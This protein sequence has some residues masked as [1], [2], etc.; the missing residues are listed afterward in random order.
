MKTTLLYKLKNKVRNLFGIKTTPNIEVRMD[1]LN[2]KVSD[3]KRNGL[4]EMIRSHRNFSA[5]DIEKSILKDRD[6]I[7][8]KEEFNALPFSRLSE[9]AMLE[10]IKIVK[11]DLKQKSQTVENYTDSVKSTLDELSDK[12]DE[13]IK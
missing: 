8:V 2:H 10:I 6:N 4:R 3:E 7:S 1:L 12:L 9:D 11:L 13:N 5:Y